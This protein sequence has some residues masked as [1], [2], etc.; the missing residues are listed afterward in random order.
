MIFDCTK[1]CKKTEEMRNSTFCKG[2]A[3]FIDG[4]IV[5]SCE[6][7]SVSA[8]EAERNLVNCDY[9][10]NKIY[11]KC[12]SCPLVCKN[13]K[14]ENIL[15]ERRKIAEINALIESMKPSMIMSGLDGR[16]IN[17]ITKEYEKADSKDVSD[18]LDAAKLSNEAVKLIQSGKQIDIAYL[19]I[20]SSK[21][22]KKIKKAVK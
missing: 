14:N 18:A 3:E 9:W 1:K 4:K 22:L 11:D 16:A 2:T 20:A 10:E 7:A 17:N 12:N 5:Y 6:T 21:I 13:N 19:A 15:A 8:S